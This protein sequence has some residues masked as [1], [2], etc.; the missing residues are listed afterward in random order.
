MLKKINEHKMFFS[1]VSD[2]LFLHLKDHEHKS[3]N[4]VVAY[5]QGLN[6]FREFT[7]EVYGKGVDKLT[8]ELVT[9]DMVREYLKWLIEKK[10]ST[11]T[12]RNHRLTAIKQ[13]L[14]YC[15]D[16][17]ISLAPQYIKISKIKHV[18]VRSN[19]RNWMTRDAIRVILEQPPKT[20]IG[21]RDRFFMI[22]LYGT[23]ARV[24]EALNVRLKDL[25]IATKDPFV[26]LLGKGNKPRCVPLLDIT[27]ENLDYYL[28]VYHPNGSP[29]DYLFYTVI[30]GTK[31][32]MSVANAE[33]FIKKYGEAARRACSQV[34]ENVYPHLFRHSYGAHL[35]RMGFSLP[36]IAKLLGHESLE[37]TE[38]YAHTDA[39]MINEAFRK[40]EE[41]LQSQNSLKLK[42]KKWKLA[43]E[44]T[45]AKLYGLK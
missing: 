16:R 20:K 22:F 35:Y 4:T 12:T 6:S 40:V 42:E 23:G 37:T 45:L 43:D 2:F 3:N 11:I 44:E 13:Y 18:T 32:S 27:V 25:E 1:F 29:G 9:P 21:I 36:V 39:E 31:D 14:Q 17:D 7:K 30:K 8:F 41:S 19:K 15:S 38:I 24:S 34:P 33:R 28:S 5:R 26:R 10:G